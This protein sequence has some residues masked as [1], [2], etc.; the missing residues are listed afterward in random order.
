VIV[1]WI[2]DG[3]VYIRTTTNT[4]ALNTPEMKLLGH[5][6]TQSAATVRLAPMGAGFALVVRWINPTSVDGP[7][8][9]ELFQLTSAG[10]VVGSP[11]LITDQSRSDFTSG[12]QAPSIA[13]RAS[14]GAMLIAWHV[15][16]AGGM[17]GSCDVF[18]RMV[19]PNG[20]TSGQPFIL[21]T[22]TMG[23]QTTP[24]VASLPGPDGAF[25]AVWTDASHDAPDTS[26]SAVR[27]RVIYPAY[28]PN[29]SN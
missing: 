3:D 12:E 17:D 4:L 21:S 23:D 2:V 16:D 11:T 15:C 25:A 28:D 6:S 20:T 27:A 10:A 18:G 29:G 14:D 9:I 8:K 1:A 19:R 22:T 26:G 7:G 13:T 24:A 5:T